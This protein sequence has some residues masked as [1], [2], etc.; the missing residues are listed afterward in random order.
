MRY[1]VREMSFAEILDTGFRLLRDH[2][3]LFV[4]IAAALNLPLIVLRDA[5]TAA[6]AGS[7]DWALIVVLLIF[8]LSLAIS[9]IVGVAATYAVG[10]IYLGRDATLG[11]AF[12]KGLAIF[13]PVIGTSLLSGI[14]MFGAFLLLI[15]PGIWLTLGLIVL[16]PV[17]VLEGKFG[18]KALSRS[19]ELMKGQRLRAFGI[20]LIATGLQAVLGMGFDLALA[21]IPVIGTLGTAFIYS[22]TG[23]YVAAV[24]VVLYFDIR[25]RKEAFEV[26]QLARIVEAGTARA[27]S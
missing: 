9:P 6:T 23:A 13:T 24:S 27:A 22:V 15:I 14:A 1:E 10:E 5:L 8:A 4:G 16:S 26:E 25:C 7:V 18:G 21:A 11:D 3:V 20:L 19:L 2:F 17:M 12:R